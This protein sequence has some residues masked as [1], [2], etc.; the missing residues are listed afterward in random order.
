[1]TIEIISWSISTKVW[2]RA[3]INLATPVFAVR[4]ASVARL[5]TDCVTWSGPKAKILGR[6]C[7]E[8]I[9]RGDRGKSQV[10]IDSL[11]NSGMGSPLRSNSTSW[12][13]LLLEGILYGPLWNMM[14]TTKRKE[15]Q[16]SGPL[17]EFSGFTH[18]RLCSGLSEPSLLANAIST[19]SLCAG[20]Y[21]F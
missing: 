9:Q 11:K 2:D 1:M 13:Q 21:D 17:M 8:R 16:L 6:L 20:P 7:H 3:G 12:V 10:A 4:L 15:K 5:I 19:N 18:V 14:M